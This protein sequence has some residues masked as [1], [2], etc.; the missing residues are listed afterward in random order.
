M[1][2]LRPLLASTL[3]ELFPGARHETLVADA[4][5]RRFHRLFLP[6]GA[7]LIVMDYGAPFDGE[8]DDIRLARIFEQANLPVAHV[9]RSLPSAGALVLGD[10]GDDTL[11]SALDKAASGGRL[12]RDELY[13][14]AIQ[15]A[16]KIATQ[17]TDALLRSERAEGPALDG[18][19][20][21]F[22]MRFFLEHYVGNFLGRR[23]SEPDVRGAV[24]ALAL[25]AAAHPRVLCHRDFH[26]RNIMVRGDGSLVMVDIQDARWGPDTYDLASLLCDGY[27]DLGDRE[28]AELFDRY[29]TY[30]P[31]TWDIDE[32]RGRFDVVAAQRMIKALGTFGYQ[33]SV[34]GRERYRSG[35]PRTIERLSRLVRAREPV[36][37]LGKVMLRAG[38]LTP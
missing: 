35:I 6:D 1:S 10:L 20:F 11:E 22:E 25:K 27:V 28:A 18:D 13:S 3:H 24:E 30:L 29:L 32:L 2:V 33:I 19:R 5:T 9:M 21:L 26:S 31:E 16:A 4:S 7:T 36:A 38:L 23:D 17:G 15:L 14:S 37:S 8:T 12:S 34:L